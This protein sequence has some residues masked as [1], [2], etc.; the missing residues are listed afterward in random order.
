[1]ASWNDQAM[2]HLREIS[3]AP[4]ELKKVTTNKA[5]NSMEKR[6]PDGRGA[7]LN[8]NGTFKDFID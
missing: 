8:T 7:R 3:R 2:K 1:M 6:L 5:L 4:G